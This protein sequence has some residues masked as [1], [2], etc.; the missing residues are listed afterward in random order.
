MEAES[1][2]VVIVQS[3]E[4]E[5]SPRTYTTLFSAASTYFG[6]LNSLLLSPGLSSMTTRASTSPTSTV[7]PGPRVAAH[8]GASPRHFTVEIPAGSPTIDDSD[9]EIVVD[10]FSKG[11]LRID[12]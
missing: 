11:D 7:Q 8:G 6:L 1:R 4:A 9:D 12:K 3:R 2:H 10:G 5:T